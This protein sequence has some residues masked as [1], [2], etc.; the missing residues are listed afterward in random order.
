MVRE[1]EKHFL[2]NQFLRI[3]LYT[4]AVV[5]VAYV[6]VVTTR[7]IISNI[8]HEHQFASAQEALADGQE[9]EAY[10]LV[11]NALDYCP[12]SLPALKFAAD[13]ADRLESPDRLR[14]R[15]QVAAA[16]PQSS[17]QQVKLADTAL[18]LGSIRLAA[19]TLDQIPAAAR[20]TAAYLATAA[21]L[22][23]IQG[24][25]NEAEELLKRAV[26]VSDGSPEYLV[27]LAELQVMMGAGDA[28]Q[29]IA[30]LVQLPQLEPKIQLRVLRA[31]AEN[32]RADSSAR[33]E[34]AQQAITLDVVEF[35]DYCNYISLCSHARAEADQLVTNLLERIQKPEI[36]HRVGL[37]ALQIGHTGAVKQAIDN[38][39]QRGLESPHL[40][41]L[42]AGLLTKEASWQQLLVLLSST[43]W[44]QLDYLRGAYNSLALRNS[45]GS[46]AWKSFWSEAI[47]DAANSS[48][49]LQLL[50]ETVSNWPRWEVET[51]G[52]LW[53]F[54][55]SGR[56]VTQALDGLYS[57]YKDL[58]DAGGM[59]RVIDEQLMRNPNDPLLK[60][61]YARLSLLRRIQVERAIQLA[62]E[63][64]RELPDS[65][66]TRVTHAFAQSAAGDHQQALKE[67]SRLNPAALEDSKVAA[68]M[69]IILSR[70][71]LL[72]PAQQ[73]AEIARSSPLLVEEEKLLP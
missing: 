20:N 4:I 11:S 68:Y 39:R 14:L 24:N 27:R 46:A 57:R 21:K 55:G 5:C 65:T 9:D 59:L 6:V 30:E 29:I 70:S 2:D 53:Q 72:T 32:Q 16:K 10:Q 12:D 69:A 40:L 62:A 8:N 45:G 22:D 58:R 33:F 51:I 3:S 28:S 50:L 37:F 63:A 60:S 49:S 31:G 42:E 73:F 54:V 36:I 35:R 52:A 13:L 66:Y 47:R 34:Y 26:V 67:M 56:N 48:G 38:M 1:D 7:H 43:D 64:F 71:E 18:D 19:E 15:M 25:Q 23:F 41:A 61:E 17:Y 44:E